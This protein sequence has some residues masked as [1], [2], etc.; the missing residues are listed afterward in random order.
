MIASRRRAPRASPSRP[1]PRRAPRGAAARPRGRRGGPAPRS[2]A[3]RAGCRAG[4]GPG[5][6][7][8][9]EAGLDERAEL[10]RDRARRHAGAAR[11]LVRAER[12]SVCEHV[13]DRDRA[14]GCANATGGRL[15]RARHRGR[16]VADSG[17]ALLRVQLRLRCRSCSR[18]R[19]AARAPSTSSLHG[20]VTTRPSGTPTLRE[21][22]EYVYFRDNVAGVQR[23]WWYHRA[24]LRRLVRRR[25][26]HADE[27][28]ARGRVPPPTPRRGTAREARPPRRRADRPLAGA[29]R[30]R[31]RAD[32]HGLRGRH[33]RLRAF[34]GRQR[35]FSRSFKYHRPRGLLCCS[36]HCP[37]CMMTVDGVPER[38]R[39]RRAG[40]RGRGGRGPERPRLARPR[41]PVRRPTRSAGRSRRSASTTAR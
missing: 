33:D 32:G 3:G 28:G 37:N 13:E 7:V 14:R 25:A 26:R 34:A 1:S 30:S 15:T 35:V 8:L 10:P 9:D 29:S 18:A 2:R 22:T 6:D 39:V 17:T 38:P 20:E 24:G 21:L 12:A 11:D 19:T 23:E 36:G 31:S 27:R 40:A 5:R 4:S 16:F 41:P